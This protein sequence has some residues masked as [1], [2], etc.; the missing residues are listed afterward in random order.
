VNPPILT[1]PFRLTGSY[2][3][4]PNVGILTPGFISL[5]FLTQRARCCAS[6]GYKPA[7]IVV[8]LARWVRFGPTVPS[9]VGTPRIVWQAMHMP[10]DTS[11]S[12]FAALPL[13]RRASSYLRFVGNG[14]CGTAYAGILSRGYETKPAC[15]TFAFTA[16]G[17]FGTPAPVGGVTCGGTLVAVLT[18]GAAAASDPT[19]V[20]S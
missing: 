15:A 9:I 14:V 6:S 3:P 20:V 19:A 2:S 13:A 16:F 10:V 4:R 17:A 8:R 11:F 18:A 7:A 12:P 5:A 1:G